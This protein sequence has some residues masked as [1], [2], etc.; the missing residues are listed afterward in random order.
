MENIKEVLTSVIEQLSLVQ[1]QIV[2]QYNELETK[3]IIISRDGSY[4]LVPTHGLT[5]K[6][7][8]AYL[9]EEDQLEDIG[10]NVSLPSG[11]VWAFKYYDVV[12]LLKQGFSPKDILKIQQAVRITNKIR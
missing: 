8:E 10:D 3:Y 9:Y 7:T 6:F 12:A 1:D 11:H 4:Y 5:T 2:D